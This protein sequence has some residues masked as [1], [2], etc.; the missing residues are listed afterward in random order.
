MDVGKNKIV[1]VVT[2]GAF[3]ELGLKIGN[4]AVVLV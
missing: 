2:S 1:A 3:D 4:R